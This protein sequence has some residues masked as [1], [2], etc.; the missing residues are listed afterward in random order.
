MANLTSAQLGLLLITILVILVFICT[1][2]KSEKPKNLAKTENMTDKSTQP[3]LILYYAPWC[4]Y[5]RAM[6]PSWNNLITLVTQEKYPVELISVNCE[7]SKQQC[8]AAKINGFPTVILIKSDGEHV[9][10]QGDRSTQSLMNFI[11]KNE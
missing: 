9:Q 11:I 8:E 4:G 10:Y 3:K 1:C 5:S 7:E 6:L 2:I